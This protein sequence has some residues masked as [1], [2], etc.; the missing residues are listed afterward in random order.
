MAEGLGGAPDDLNY[1]RHTKS[2]KMVFGDVG[3]KT[4]I[5]G[6]EFLE[7]TLR[8]VNGGSPKHRNSF[9]YRGGEPIRRYLEQ[10]KNDLASGKSGI[11]TCELVLRLARLGKGLEE[12]AVGVR[13]VDV[14]KE[15]QAYQSKQVSGWLK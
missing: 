10:I 2:K 6:I 3:E 5:P 7:P 13:G 14:L 8:R 9:F 12:Y 15:L 4:K 11:K 1:I